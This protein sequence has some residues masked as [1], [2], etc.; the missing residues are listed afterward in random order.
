[1]TPTRLPKGIIALAILAG[2][3]CSHS[4][5][6]SPRFR[7]GDCIVFTDGE[8]W[9]NYTYRVIEVGKQKYHLE[10]LSKLESGKWIE[11][12]NEWPIA[13][14]DPWFKRVPCP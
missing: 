5:A 11:S 1:M 3:G 12:A 7:A 13:T 8:R 2:V 4:E 10:F 9:E 6:P 14:R